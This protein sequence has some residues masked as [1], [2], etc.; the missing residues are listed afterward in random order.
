VNPLV[1]AA[2]WLALGLLASALLRRRTARMVAFVPLVGAG[3]TLLVARS[4]TAA[5]PLGGLG[6]ISGLDRAGQGVLVATGISMTLVILLQ[7]S[8]DVSIGRTIG[9]VGAAATIAM[10]SSDPL[11]TALALTVA[12]ATL[13]LRWIGQSPG[14]A[15]LAAGR[16]T[17]TGTAALVAASPLLPLAGFTTGARPIVVGV[18]L[19]TGVAALL[20]VY[21]LGGWAAG[22][23]GSLRPLDVAPWLILLVPV[24]LLI[25]ER[26][27]GGVLGDG[28]A[29]FEHVLLVVGLGSAVWGGIWAV[30]GPAAIRYGRVFMADIALCIAAV[31]GAPVSPALSGALIIL[32]THL[33][34]APIL[35]RSEEAGLLWPRRVAWALLSG[36]PPAPSFWGRF[37]LLEALAAGNVGSTIAAVIAIGA[38]FIAAVL[39]CSTRARL[40][41]ASGWRHRL[42]DLTAWLLVAVGIA[43]GLAPHSLSA[44]VFGG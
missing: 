36:V 9:I 40:K 21:P 27:P 37:L 18:L 42:P 19:A 7:P 5:V 29:V 23:I 28:S 22:I 24:V 26:I 16:V 6:A 32:V 10:A 8:I 15:T 20:A 2:V 43:I 44:Y 11:V 3:L 30:R 33:T 34:L 13:V 25:G 35:L 39:A 14:R 4:S 17:G 41:S 38:I 1:T 12:V 31:E